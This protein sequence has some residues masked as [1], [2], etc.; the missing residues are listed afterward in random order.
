MNDEWNL[1]EAPNSVAASFEARLEGSADSVS[2]IG[3]V[4]IV[5]TR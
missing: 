1:D 5:E 2:E 3:S 4:T